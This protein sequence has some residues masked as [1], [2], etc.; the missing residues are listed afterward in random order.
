MVTQLDHSNSAGGPLVATLL[1]VVG[2]AA[3]GGGG[4]GGASAPATQI[5]PS[6]ERQLDIARQVYGVTSPYPAD[7]HREAD[8]YP[9][10]QT[11]TVH[12]RENEVASAPP[13]VDFESCTDDFATALQWSDVQAGRRGYTTTLMGNSE[14]DWYF[15][16]DREI[17]ST[18]PA[19]LVNRVFKC[20]TL[21]RS[22]LASGHVARLRGQNVA[23]TDLKFAVEYLWGFSQFNNA[24]HA[25][26]NSRSINAS[27]PT[28]TIQRA[29]AIKQSGAGQCDLIEV[30]TH[31]FVL[32]ANSGLIAESEEF[33]EVFR[34]R[35]RAGAAQ[36]CTE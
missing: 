13:A 8:P 21:D 35:L 9:D 31:Q 1:L 32:D 2:L 12:V 28:H 3:C 16:F 33:N 36:L 17:Q 7:F 25:V 22:V 5:E 20:S 26:V 15:Q 24:L 19:M 30:W 18:E 14:S 6:A 29:E 23:I 4:G 11:L 10:R 27:S 34:A